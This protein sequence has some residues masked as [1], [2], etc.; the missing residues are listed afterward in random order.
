MRL[1][2]LPVALL[3]LG[4]SA[5]A[6]AAGKKPKA[7]PPA[8][9]PAVAPAPTPANSPVGVGAANAGSYQLCLLYSGCALY[10]TSTGFNGMNPA[11]PTQLSVTPALP[12]TCVD[13]AALPS[14]DVA[15]LTNS[16]VVRVTPAGAATTLVTRLSQGAGPDFAG[17]QLVL[18]DSGN[19]TVVR[20]GAPPTSPF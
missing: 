5:P 4:L 15:V 14:G 11:N 19:Q 20:V 10:S 6:F 12:T 18:L 16:S 13:V 9:A 1:H 3:A 8:R 17:G 7:A 2:P